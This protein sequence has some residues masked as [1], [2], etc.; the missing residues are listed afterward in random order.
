[1]EK[2]VLPLETVTPL[3]LGG[4]KAREAELRPPAFRGAMRYWYRAL[5]GGIYGDQIDLIHKYENEVFGFAGDKEASVAS[6]LVV[7]LRYDGVPA[8]IRFERDRTDRVKQF[9]RDDVVKPSGKDYL[10]WSMAAIRRGDIPK[11]YFPEQMP[12]SLVLSTRPGCSKSVLDEAL[13]AAWLMIHLGGIG[14]RSRHAG[15]CFSAEDVNVNFPLKFQIPEGNIK[16][17]TTFLQQ[18]LN[19]IRSRKKTTASITNPPTFDVLAPEY[20][21][22]W[23]LGSWNSA[24]EA[25]NAIGEAIWRFRA[26]RPKDHDGVLDWCKTN[27]ITEVE[28]AIFGL[29]IQFRYTK[30]PTAMVNGSGVQRRASPLWLKV[31][32]TADNKYVGVATLFMSEFLPNGGEIKS[33]KGVGK[34]DIPTDYT[35]ISAFL[36]E[37]FPSK[38]VVEYE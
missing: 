33:K 20:C 23:V 13:S 18:N 17:V 27:E 14:A 2:I 6:S 28:R 12:L 15:G 3:F 9:G 38:E 26:Y 36:D 25:L 8:P 7:R 37:K 35:L 4:S 10:Y 19:S 1:M 11:E 16:S 32:K 24:D 21:K 22:I 31:S 5:L 34:F 30:G 29:P